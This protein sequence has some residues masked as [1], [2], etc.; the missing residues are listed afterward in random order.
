MENIGLNLASAIAQ[1][2][3]EVNEALQGPLSIEERAA[4]QQE[5]FELWLALVVL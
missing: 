2:M 4:L 1:R 5:R 3:Q